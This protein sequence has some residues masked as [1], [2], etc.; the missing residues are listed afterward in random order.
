M[1][2]LF[3]RP[4]PVLLLLFVLLF[5]EKEFDGERPFV[6]LITLPPTDLNAEGVTL[7]G[8]F[9]DLSGGNV[10]D[11]GFL[12]DSK[13]ISADI[14]INPDILKFSLKG[15]AT[16]V[17]SFSVRVESNLN[18]GSTYYVRAYAYQGALLVIGEEV[19][20]KSEGGSVNPLI[21]DFL[22]I[23]LV[24]GDTI[25]I[26]GKNFTLGNPKIAIKLGGQNAELIGAITDTQL[27]IRA[28]LNIPLNGKVEVQV[29][30][31]E[32]VSSQNYQ[33]L[34]PSIINSPAVVKYGTSFLIEC[35]NLSKYSSSTNVEIGS[36]GEYSGCNVLQQQNN[37][38]LV[39]LADIPYRVTGNDSIKVSTASLTARAKINLAKPSILSVTPNIGMTG[40][41]ITL[42]VDGVSSSTDVTKIFWSGYQ[43]PFTTYSILPGGKQITFQVP[44][45]EQYPK[46]V[47]I[48]IRSG[49]LLSNAISFK[50]DPVVAQLPQNLK[51]WKYAFSLNDK[52]YLGTA[53]TGVPFQRIDPLRIGANFEGISSSSPLSFEFAFSIQ[54]SRVIALETGANGSLSAQL[55]SISPNNSI[56]LLSKS[57]NQILLKPGFSTPGLI[58]AVEIKNT[59]LSYVYAANG[60]SN[61]WQ[62]DP[63]TLQFKSLAPI[64]AANNLQIQELI[65][66]DQG[67]KV[68]AIVKLQGDDFTSCMQYIPS[69]N[70]WQ[71][72]YQMFT[73]SSFYHDGFVYPI[74]GEPDFYFILAYK[75]GG[76]FSLCS[77]QERITRIF[78]IIYYKQS[79]LNRRVF[80]LQNQVVVLDEE[81]IYRSRFLQ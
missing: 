81:N 27:K 45:S 50:L 2:K 51:N 15:E 78:P 48:T 20:F 8:E 35:T 17:G 34:R 14:A 46:D 30:S 7:N 63:N 37:T 9:L 73:G 23:N 12:I 4:I 54:N 67:E 62:Y 57:S 61:F 52:L 18:V 49:E 79:D 58:R 31:V 64:P 65:L 40:D 21:N 59:K 28:P 1:K 41:E 25:T 56:Q 38:L 29:G 19:S 74:A 53:S 47:T 66:L 33:R 32:L 72:R 11:Y 76:S 39:S 60:S 71:T 3:T 44:F 43:L 77:E 26:N 70:T 13:K 68:F 5:C 36:N 16:K 22:P 69:T 80:L 24:P 75:T 55:L 42:N 6:R 10:S